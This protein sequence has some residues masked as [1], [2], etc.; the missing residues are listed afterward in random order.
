MSEA[1]V[2]RS[3][4]NML[5]LIRESDAVFIYVAKDQKFLSWLRAFESSVPT[6]VDVKYGKGVDDRTVVRHLTVKMGVSDKD[7]KSAVA[8]AKEQA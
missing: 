3:E 4:R 8:K 6:S 7:F 1:K 5:K 2:S